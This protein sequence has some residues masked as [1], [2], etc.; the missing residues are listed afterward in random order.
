MSAKFDGMSNWLY[1]MDKVV[2]EKLFSTEIMRQVGE[3]SVERIYSNTKRGRHPNDQGELVKNKE[4]SPK[5]I[6]YRKKYS[7][8]AAQTGDFFSPKRSNL[9][10]TGQLLDSIDMRFIGRRLIEIFIPNT[11]RKPPVSISERPRKPKPQKTNKEV[12]ISLFLNGRPFMRMDRVGL[13]TIRNM[14]QRDLRSKLRAYRL[15]NKP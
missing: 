3:F 1:R 2:R 11:R 10:L 9:T 7:K 13:R 5:Y 8:I 4:L 12:A 15:K 14:F 6:E